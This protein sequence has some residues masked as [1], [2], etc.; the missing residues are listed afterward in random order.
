MNLWREIKADFRLI[1]MPLWEKRQV[2]SLFTGITDPEKA[3]GS[4]G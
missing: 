4:G 2:M 1:K 3:V